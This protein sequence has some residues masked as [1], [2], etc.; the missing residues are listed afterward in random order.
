[1]PHLQENNDAQTMK[2][3]ASSP[4]RG[5]A[6]TELP[7]KEAREG[8]LSGSESPSFTA[9]ASKLSNLPKKVD[10][11]GS[12]EEQG[13]PRDTST[14][15]SQPTKQSVITPSPFG[16]MVHRAP[17]MKYGPVVT[18]YGNTR[19]VPSP[20]RVKRR[21]SNSGEEDKVD[22]RSPSP[23]MAQ[24]SNLRYR[25]MYSTPP[26]K[27]LVNKFAKSSEK[28]SPRKR[29][30]GQFEFNE[31]IKKAK[32]DRAESP[33]YARSSSVCGDDEASQ[34]SPAAPVPTKKK[35][36]ISPTSSGEKGEDDESTGTA[37]RGATFPFTGRG[38][39]YP[40][41]PP[42]YAS[43]HHPYGAPPPPY[44]SA[45]PMYNGYPPPPPPHYM[46]GH[47]PPFYPPYPPHPAM[48]H[49]HRPHS[50]LPPHYAG[51]PHRMPGN[52]MAPVTSSDVSKKGSA[53]QPTT[54]P[55]P[56]DDRSSAIQSVAEWQR[57]ALTTGKPP[58]AKRCVPLTEPIPSKYWG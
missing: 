52:E 21:V 35:R 6:S 23:K 32:T 11:F 4:S 33:D 7:I 3:E 18:V 55:S 26:S 13:T 10:S 54:A 1:M 15:R 24:P 17:E 16:P 48:M 20:I 25:D 42:P 12:T 51:S 46:G 39:P 14:P 30:L 45:Y 29:S 2:G 38:Y 36:M 43:H 8:Y 57:A 19:L 5:G 37:P 28:E 34:H 41:H 49:H 9:T 31:A 44:G 53:A 56:P 47:P 22:N 40:P 50:R 27:A 58:S